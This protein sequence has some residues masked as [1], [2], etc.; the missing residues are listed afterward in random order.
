[1]TMRTIS[2]LRL[3]AVFSL[4][5]AFPVLAGDKDDDGVPN[6]YDLCPNDPEDKDELE[7]NDGCPDVDDDKDGVCDAFV[8]EGGLNSKYASVCKGSDKCKRVAEDRDGFEDDDGCPDPDNDKDG[9]PDSKDKCTGK[10][11]DF[12]G[13]EDNDG[14]PDPD[15]DK[16]GVC[17]A[18][19]SE[20][21]VGG[22]YAAACLG[23]DK[24]PQASED[25]DNFED[26]DG[27]PDL[28]NDKDGIP[29]DKDKCPGQAETINTVDDEDGCPDFANPAI[30][31][32]M[33]FPLVR[34]RSSTAELTFEA[35]QPL[36]MFAKQLVEYS[37]KKVELRLF[38]WYKG[39]KKEDYLKLLRDRS[40]VVV[41][42][43]VGKGVKPEQL[44]ELT[45]SVENF[46]AFKGTEQ[47]FN[48]EK[49]MESHLLE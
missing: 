19:I 27:C 37:D 20:K 16:D 14:C 48:Q 22:D 42:Y 26:E 24:C 49:P 11:E 13:Y 1:M 6:K 18:W 31:T 43:L 47:D 2:L 39:K 10:V 44:K 41:D 23:A 34:F 12:D 21:G 17:D 29:D 46:D 35:Q 38:T 30:E 36:D 25:K 45:Y 9:I 8:S 32:V 15:N 7:D 33:T 3:C 28:D 4:C 5:L 40:K